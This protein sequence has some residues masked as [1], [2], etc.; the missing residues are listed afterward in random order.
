MQK[1]G[2][3]IEQVQLRLGSLSAE[4]SAQARPRPLVP[5]PPGLVASAARLLRELRSLQ[6]RL[7]PGRRVPL[8][9][10]PKPKHGQPAPEFTFGELAALLAETCVLTGL[11]IERNGLDQ[12]AQEEAEVAAIREMLIR[13][14]DEIR[15]AEQRLNLEG[16]GPRPL[17]DG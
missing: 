8:P 9:A 11:L 14:I 5:A 6:M 15:A 10:L 4:V 1:L 3:W 12:T 2:N 13:R 7:P 17:N 16:S